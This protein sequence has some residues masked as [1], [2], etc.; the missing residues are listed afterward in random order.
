MQLG[1]WPL[2]CCQQPALRGIKWWTGPW[3]HC[4]VAL[5]LL[6][7]FA[8]DGATKDCSSHEPKVVPTRLG[9]L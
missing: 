4:P 9:A 3:T 6:T 2:L 5:F 7:S 1:D 8:A